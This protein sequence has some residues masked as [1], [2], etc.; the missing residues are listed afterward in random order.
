MVASNKPPLGD[1]VHRSQGL[2]SRSTYNPYYSEYILISNIPPRYRNANEHQILMDEIVSLTTQAQL[3]IDTQDLE[4]NISKNNFLCL[5][6]LQNGC[7]IVKL[8]DRTWIGHGGV[9]RLHYHATKKMDRSDKTERT[10]KGAILCLP[11]GYEQWVPTSTTVLLTGTGTYRVA[12][13]E[14]AMNILSIYLNDKKLGPF[15]IYMNLYPHKTRAGNKS[16]QVFTVITKKDLSLSIQKKDLILTPIH[17]QASEGVIL[18]TMGM[19]FQIYTEPNTFMAGTPSKELFAARN[20][21]CIDGFDI[22]HSKR[23]ILDTLLTRMEPEQFRYLYMTKGEKKSTFTIC[24]ADGITTNLI[25]DD[26]FAGMEAPGIPII[27]RPYGTLPGRGDV[28]WY[29]FTNE[30]T[31]SNQW[32]TPTPGKTNTGR[33]T[34]PPS[35]ISVNSSSISS[36]ADNKT[37]TPHSYVDGFTT[38]HRRR[39]LDTYSE[40]LTQS[41]TSLDGSSITSA[42]GGLNSASSNE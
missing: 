24:L 30:P 28:E 26:L 31:N 17:A 32:K 3:T 29:K 1:P 5:F 11:L 8:K 18:D 35:R 9:D 12:E 6:T 13:N 19:L 42:A 38:V 7:A 27:M 20:H 33:G 23:K 36:K 21:L 40:V 37:N 25:T 2:I 14:A 16:E 22:E 34:I 4:K 41:Q 15:I 10:W 39:N